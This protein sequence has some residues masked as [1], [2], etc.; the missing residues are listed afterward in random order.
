VTDAD[1][2][3]AAGYPAH[4]PAHSAAFRSVQE[5]STLHESREKSLDVPT[6]AKTDYPRQGSLNP[7]R[8]REN[9]WFRKTTSLNPHLLP[10]ATK[11]FGM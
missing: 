1:F 6:D 4:Y 7:R 3:R 10:L 11:F 2:E 8:H 9:R 5:P